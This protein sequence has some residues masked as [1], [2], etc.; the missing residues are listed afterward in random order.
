[1]A[2]MGLLIG[3]FL[4]VCILRVPEGLS[5]ARPASRCP[6]C[7]HQLAWFENIPVASFIVLRRRC[8]ICHAPISWQYPAI[9]L[10]TCA[11]FV[12]ATLRFGFSW[13]LVSRLAVMSAMIV[14]FMIGL[15]HRVLPNAITVPGAVVGVLCSLPSEPGWAASLAGAALGAGLLALAEIAS[16]IRHADVRTGAVRMLPMIGAFLGWQVLLLT[17]ALGLLVWAL[18]GLVSPAARGGRGTVL[19]YASALAGAALASAFAGETMV[20]WCL[21]FAS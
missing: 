8:R 10:V 7:G 20:A 5:V 6:G 3:S 17:L 2:A 15:R 16:R 19:P 21:R 4:N 12:A 9:E 11:V 18:A 13:L 1:M 14:L